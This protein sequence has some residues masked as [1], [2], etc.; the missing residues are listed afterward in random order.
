MT[1][2]Q[3][4]EDDPAATTVRPR[5][6][7]TIAER[8]GVKFE[9]VDTGRCGLFGE[10]IIQACT[11]REVM[12]PTMVREVLGTYGTQQEAWKR[13]EQELAP[14]AVDKLHDPTL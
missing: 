9:I 10:P 8:D 13:L 11:F 2:H 12:R 1:E 7:D 6:Y 5:K 3:P 4:S 14:T